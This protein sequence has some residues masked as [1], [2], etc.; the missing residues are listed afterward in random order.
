MIFSLLDRD[1][2]GDFFRTLGALM[3]LMAILFLADTLVGSLGEVIGNGVGFHWIMLYY[4]L[5]LP[6]FFIE[7]LV[8]AAAAAIL[9]VAT[10]KARLN[11]TLAWMAGGLSP[12]RISRPLI[13]C[14]V[15]LA[16]LSIG[17]NE[18]FAQKAR[19][20]A[21]RVEESIIEGKDIT[22]SENIYQRG[23]EDRI[24]IIE[25]FD[26][27]A[28]RMTEPT[29][30]ELYPETRSPRKIVRAVSAELDDRVENKWVFLDATVRK[31]DENGHLKEYFR[32]GRYRVELEPKLSQFLGKLDDPR[33]MSMLEL[34]AYIKLIDAQGK[35]T[36]QLWM[37]LHERFALLTGIA[38]I[39]LLMCAHGISPKT[40][41]AIAGFG[42]GLAWI[43]A[44]Y[45]VTM[46]S[47]EI[48][49]AD[50]GLP[51]VIVAWFPNVLFGV[52][53]ATMI[54]KR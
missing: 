37:Q 40:L 42:G 15:L 22:R 5:R 53:G 35:D 38:I 21:E 14:S 51:P 26:S 17:A 4:L 16:I 54:W 29:V 27:A 2:A 24:Y 23:S 28:E 31:F 10:R 44:W 41:G 45:G 8:L 3:A 12:F 7:V 50:I 47:H 18:L 46:L 9:W 6:S 11:E 33:T 36:S 34:R 48:A 43:A 25:S 30:I 32:E 49:E 1:M 19:R 52:I 39:G 20:F 13:A